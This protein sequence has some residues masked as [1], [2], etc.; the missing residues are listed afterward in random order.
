MVFLGYQIFL[1]SEGLRMEKRTTLRAATA[2]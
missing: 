2:I 1:K